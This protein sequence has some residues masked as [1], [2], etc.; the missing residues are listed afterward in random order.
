ML[1]TFMTTITFDT[2]KFA[3]TLKE[4]GVPATQAEAEARAVAAAI[5]ETLDDA[6]TSP[7]ET[8][9]LRADLRDRPVEESREFAVRLYGKAVCARPGVPGQLQARPVFRPPV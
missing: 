3:N 9:D 5:R 7:R 1:V 6:V 4:A 8:S 2:L